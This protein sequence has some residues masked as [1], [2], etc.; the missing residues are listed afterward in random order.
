MTDIFVL[1][2]SHD[3]DLVSRLVHALRKLWHVTW[4]PD[5]PHGDWE[6]Y[7]RSEIPRSRCVVAVLPRKGGI[8][9][10]DILRDEMHHAK[11]NSIPLIPF[12]LGSE[13]MPMGFGSLARVEASEWDGSVHHAA[14]CELEAKLKTL[15]GEP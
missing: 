10:T 15:L 9:R 12:R 11:D 5:I 14:Y 2:V 6:E 3:A 13:P 1:Y 8:G 7:V 4:A